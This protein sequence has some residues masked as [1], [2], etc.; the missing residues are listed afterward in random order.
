MMITEHLLSGFVISNIVKQKQV[1]AVTFFIL[2]VSVLPDVPVVFLGTPGD[3]NYLAH[4]IYSHSLLLVP[5]YTILPSIIAYYILKR[6]SLKTSFYTIYLLA[7]IAYVTHIFLDFLNPYGVH[8]FYPLSYTIYSADFLH[9]FD[10]IAIVISIIFIIYFSIALF[11]GKNNKLILTYLL[12]T[13]LLYSLFVFA[14][15][16]FFSH[17]YKSEIIRTYADAKYLTTVPRTFWRW[18]GIAHTEEKMITII[19]AKGKYKLKEY[20]KAINVPISVINNRDYR[21]FMQYARFPIAFKQSNQ[22]HFV[23]LIY[24]DNSYRLTF[25]ID[26]YEEV[27][28]TELTGFDFIDRHDKD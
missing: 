2:I 1:L 20:E 25:H 15:R 4:R 22:L 13:V 10:P 9:S 3:V 24:S 21:L 23:N 16:E 17:N 19:R 5:A 11:R 26:D 6:H 8:L 7:N 27:K 18:K 12:F 28:K 14:K